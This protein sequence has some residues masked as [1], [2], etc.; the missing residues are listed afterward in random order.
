MQDVVIG[1]YRGQVS[2]ASQCGELADGLA[3]IRALMHS[4]GAE[5]LSEG[6]NLNVRLSLA[7]AGRDLSLVV[8]AFGRQNALRDLIS[9]RGGSKARRNWIAATALWSAGVGTPR[10]IAFLERWESRSLVESYFI[11][12]YQDG[13]SSF[14]DELAHL[15]REESECD[16]IISLMQCVAD[17]VRQMH[18][19]GL[20]HNDLGNQNVLLRR[21][22]EREWGDVQFI[23]LNRSR[24]RRQ[25]TVRECARDISRIY[26]PSDL[27]RVFKEMYW[28]NTPPSDSFQGWERH[29]R[30]RYAFHSATRA[31]RHPLRTLRARK[32][33]PPRFAYPSE[34][35]IWIWDER[36][37]QAIVTMNSGDR[38]ANYPS[39]SHLRVI[40]ATLGGLLPVWRIYSRLMTKAYS[41]PVEVKDH[42]GIAISPSH[43]RID[44]Q[45]LLLE[46][47]GRIPVLIRFYHHESLD[48]WDFCADAVRRLREAGHTVSIAFVQDRNAVKF[49]D[50]WSAFVDYVLS[51]VSEQIDMAELGHAINRV[52][53]GVWG[54][55]EYRRFLESVAE[56]CGRY[57]TVMFTGP[58]VIDFEY[59]YVLAALRCLPSNFRFGA[60]SHHLYVDRRG[61]P[62]NRQSGFSALEKFALAKAIAEFSPSCDPRLIVSEVNW[63]ILGTGVYSPVGAPYDSPGPRCNDPSVS[64]DDYADFMIRYLAM[65]ICSGFVDRAYW[66]R[67]VARGY[68]LV[69]DSN[70]AAWIERSAFRML[71]AFLRILGEAEFEEYIEL[72]ADGAL[73]FVFAVSEAERIC[74]AYSTGQ[75]ESVNLPFEYAVAMDAFGVETVTDKRNTIELSGRPVYLVLSQS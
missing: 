57:P 60:L 53:W 19:A 61:A 13:V 30:R 42:V 6:R 71:K 31:A 1:G 9:S 68:G 43:D 64:E 74:L 29:Y 24:I 55:S 46:Q 8:K 20:L 44:R 47:L 2:S 23:D 25:L 36:S 32:G 14:A 17:A 7:V 15:F 56:V 67:L 34:K 40:T 11:A 22:G 62:E 72:D 54:F 5:V 18:A 33:G 38:A 70:P 10:P 3:G 21:T 16:K 26:L 49:P 12:E 66:W 50:R 4:E 52:K 37:G 28:G 39:S 58:A 69:D 45:F 65:A 35:D 48:R 41:R 75:P 59:Q 51:K 73:G 27:L 63:P